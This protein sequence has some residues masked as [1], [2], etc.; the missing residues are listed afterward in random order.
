MQTLRLISG[1]IKNYGSIECSTIL[2]NGFELSQ[3]NIFDNGVIPRT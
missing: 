3:E 2:L 1:Y